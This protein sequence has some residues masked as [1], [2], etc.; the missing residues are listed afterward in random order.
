MATCRRDFL[1][2]AVLAA[3][4]AGR[5]M[6]QEAAKPDEIRAVLL[7]MGLNMWGD[8]RMAGEVAEE[9]RQYTPDHVRFDEAIWRKLIDHMVTR[10][11]NMVVIDLGEFMKF[12]SHP[13][14]AVKGSWEPDRL[15]AEVQRLKGLGLEPIP[16]LN[17]S[18]THDAWLQIYQRMIATQKYYQVVRDLIRDVVEV[19]GKPRLFHLGF[20]EEVIGNQQGM[21]Y[22]CLRQ[23]ELWWH[24]FLYTIRCVEEAGS[25]AWVWSDYGWHHPDYFTRC[26]KSV[27]QSNWYYDEANADFSLDEKVNAHAY[28]LKE[29]Y[30]LE[31][32]G[33]DQIPCGTNWVGWKRREAK[34]GADDVIGKL[35]PY[36]RKII[37]PERLKGFLMAPWSNCADE[38]GLTVNTKGIDLF[39]ACFK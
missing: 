22:V 7:H 15:R 30:N 31:K 23:G 20:D 38:E 39:A 27:M 5:G 10:R 33:F 24:D 37:A 6:A 21:S 9:G 1:K 17:F 13:E 36:C 12:P 2:G 14:L 28:R 34:V 35:V 19:F 16:K 25:R 8:W 32:A 3:A 4:A 11:M 18:T 29:F 26:P